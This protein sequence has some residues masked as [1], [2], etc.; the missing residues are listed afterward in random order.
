MSK[1]YQAAILTASY[2]GLK[3]P[4]APTIGTATASGLSASVTFTAPSNIGGGAI[5][6]YTVV[7]SP[8]GITGTGAS[9]PVTVS[10]LTS[11][12]SY[13]FTVVA[14]NA[15][16]SGPASAASNSITAVDPS[17]FIEN[18]FSTYL[19]TGNGSTQ[20]FTT[21]IDLS[22]KGGMVWSKCR[23]NGGTGTNEIHTLID[24]L[25]GAG[26]RLSSEDTG[27]QVYNS[28]TVT[29]FN[30]TGFSIGNS[31]INNTNNYT[32]T[33]WTFREQPKF[34]D[35]VTYT[36]NGSQP[37]TITHNLGSV[38]G[39]IIVKRT[40]TSSD[41]AVYHRA[42]DATNP[43]GYRLEL[44]TTGERIATST[45]WNDQ[46]PTATE[47]YIGSATYNASGGTYVA[48]LFAHNAGGFG[49]SGTDNVISCGS[50]TGSNSSA[51]TV[52]L[53]YEPQWVMIKRIEASGS[54]AWWIG[55][56]M[57]GLNSQ[58]IKR[59]EAWTSDAEANT[60]NGINPTS[61][62]FVLPYGTVLNDA[63]TSSYIYIAIRR[64]PMAT[65]TSGTSVFAAN[66]YT[67][68][69]AGT[70][71]NLGFV[72]DTLLTMRRNTSNFDILQARLMGQDYAFTNDTSAYQGGQ[73]GIPAWDANTGTT[74]LTTASSVTGWN[75]S[76]STYVNEAFG[77]APGFHDVVCYT[78]TGNVGSDATRITHNLGVAPEL[79]IAKSRSNAY[80]WPVYTAT[81]GVNNLL[82]LDTTDAVS[83]ISGI[84]ATTAPTST[85]F[86]V[87]NGGGSYNN[88]AGMT[89]VAYLFATC[90]G[91]SKV[92]SY[93]GT[94]TTLQVNCGFT[95]GSR[96]VLIKRTD[97]TGDW[98]VW[99]SARGIIA[100]NDPYLLLNST[101]AEVTNT[102]YVDTYSAGFELSSTAPAGINASG[103]TYIFLAI[104]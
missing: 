30:S 80:G 73:A 54:P 22:T 40:D 65:P 87:S 29:S 57:R 46:A 79:I 76:G 91:V 82:L 27:G 9:S 86:G 15:Y 89:Y 69:T 19:Y 56:I 36:G 41:W 58:G 74:K 8:G 103:G 4:N 64:G 26:Y 104:A 97:S 59:L 102:D 51:V 84:W 83:A 43:D 33:S 45:T 95:S 24:T 35:I 71:F 100:G 1:R 5:T 61:T 11:G 13:T 77:R 32:Y 90:A 60:Y 66:A 101:A 50:Y 85:T 37:R 67:G 63:A 39:C 55:D 31:P 20:T 94:G 99:D 12:T 81:G 72:P 38:P 7:S 2:N 88:G 17:A 70:S 92:G 47:F 48:Y 28:N 44:N 18:L 62:G 34:F 42:V 49:T 96:F 16:G 78:G 98:Y 3:V 23:S 25:R 53:G 75:A 21:G 93:T 6:G 52:N 10:G 14:N 68:G